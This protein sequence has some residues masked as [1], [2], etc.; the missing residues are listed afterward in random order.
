MSGKNERVLVGSIQK[1][2]VE[3]GPGIRTTVFFKGCPLNCRWCHNPEMI[4]GD[5]QL[6]RSPNNCIGCG[7]CV[8]ICPQGAVSIDSQEGVVI[9]RTRC[10]VCLKC[11]E[12]CYAKALR[13]VAKP[14]T[15]DEII[16]IVVQ[17]KGFY[18]NTGGGMTVSGGE[19]LMHADFAG[20]LIDEAG[21]RGISVC[22]DTSGFGDADALKE[23]A[24][25]ENV[26]YIL[27]DMKS[28]DDE[29]HREY[30][31]VSLSLIHIS[32]PTRPY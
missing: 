27:Y 12:N 9:D 13:A 10:N 8:D 31:G 2:S 24:C 6:I 28:I 25:K 14:M 4:E 18:D 23:L 19:I 3:D 22:L 21:R 29:V 5:Q 1:F 26:T 15:V 20:R 11:A 32:E 30:T 7:Y 16:A 17:D